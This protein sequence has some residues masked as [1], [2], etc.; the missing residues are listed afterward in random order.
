MPIS[1]RSHLRKTRAAIYGWK[2]RGLFYTSLQPRETNAACN[3]H[4]TATEALIEA[5]RR[6]LPLVWEN[7][8]EI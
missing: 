6:H 4:V 8:D 5:N 7:P 3:E 1:N 2:E